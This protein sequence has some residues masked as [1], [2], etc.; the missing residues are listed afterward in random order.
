MAESTEQNWDAKSL[1]ATMYTHPCSIQLY[2]SNFYKATPNGTPVSGLALSERSM[3][4]GKLHHY[5][6][7]QL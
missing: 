7:I 4:A 1:C 2:S 3:R 6:I 5:L